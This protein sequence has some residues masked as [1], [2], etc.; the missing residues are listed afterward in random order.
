MTL[1]ILYDKVQYGINEWFANR[2]L[3]LLKDTF[4]AK[5]VLKENL[6]ADERYP[7][8]AVVRTIDP[9]LSKKM[10]EAGT[11][12]INPSR[13]SEICNDKSL[14]YK[15]AKEAG[16]SFPEVFDISDGIMPG[17]ASYPV[18]LKTCAGHGG[19]GVRLCGSEDELKKSMNEFEGDKL[20][21][22]RLL[23]SGKS[24]KDLRVY[25]LGGRIFKAVLRSSEKDFRSNF[26]LGGRAEPYELQEEDCIKVYKIVKALGSPDFI[27]VDFLVYGGELFFNEVEDV[28][29]TRM[30]YSVYG[31]DAA[32]VFADYIKKVYEA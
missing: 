25:V 11:R 10:E 16:L 5:I 1:W 15:L 21:A 14:T 2:L 24:G 26:S 22:Q 6:T 4:D 19:K 32:E 3:E 7:D 23:G 31:I 27:G 13:I 20:I 17:E 28:V 29:G 9:L 18:V 12:V 30:L 8:L